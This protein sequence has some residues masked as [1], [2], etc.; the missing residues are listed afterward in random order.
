MIEIL[1]N[2]YKPMLQKVPLQAHRSCHPK[3]Q[4]TETSQHREP[5]L[6]PCRKGTYD[7]LIVCPRWE[8]PNILDKKA[9]ILFAIM[10]LRHL[11]EEAEEQSLVIVIKLLYS[12]L[13][14]WVFTD[15]QEDFQV[16]WN[17]SDDI[18]KRSLRD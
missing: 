9:S 8:N 18:G 10:C 12:A 14:T 7:V 1:Q 6:N 13:T 17:R 15:K 5:N 2:L 11:Q 16:L 4:T 3:I